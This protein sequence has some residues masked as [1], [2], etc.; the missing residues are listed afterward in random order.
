[1][2]NWLSV[3]VGHANSEMLSKTSMDRNM[4]VT[5]KTKVNDDGCWIEMQL[6]VQYRESI[7]LI[8]L[9]CSNE[10][11]VLSCIACSPN[12]S[13]SEIGGTFLTSSADGHVWIQ[14]RKRAQIWQLMNDMSCCMTPL[15]ATVRL[16]VSGMCQLSLPVAFWPLH[17][18]MF[19]QRGVDTTRR[20]ISS[21]Q[22]WRC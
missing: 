7:F 9:F 12:C 15:C 8:Y 22:F 21:C 20:T 13:L 19:T 1:M 4:I 5:P 10:Q 14:S 17:S 3:L 2:C 16:F 18:L 11:R 6:N